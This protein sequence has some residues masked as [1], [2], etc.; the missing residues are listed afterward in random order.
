MKLAENG[1]GTKQGCGLRCPPRQRM[2][3]AKGMKGKKLE[4]GILDSDLSEG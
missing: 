4:G 2:K 3:Q 1:E